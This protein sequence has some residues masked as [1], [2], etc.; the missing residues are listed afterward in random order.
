[1]LGSDITSREAL[2]GV[3]KIKFILSNYVYLSENTNKGL[4]ELKK[5]RL[6]LTTTVNPQQYELDKIFGVSIAKKGLFSSGKSL[7]FTYSGIPERRVA[8]DTSM[9]EKWFI[10]IEDAKMGKYPQMTELG[11]LFEKS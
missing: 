11:Q 7:Q 9:A 10:A 6:I 5:G 1:M 4:L 3:Q 8:V 2:T